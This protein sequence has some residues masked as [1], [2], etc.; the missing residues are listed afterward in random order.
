MELERRDGT[1][2]PAEISHTRLISFAAAFAAVYGT[3]RLFPILVL[4]GG[5]G[6]VFSTTE[7][8][9]PLLG[10]VLGPYAGPV[11]AVVGTFLGI[12][13]TGRTNFFGLDFLAP[14]MNALVLGLLMRR[15]W[16]LSVLIYSALLAL[17]FVH[18][19]TL[20][21]VSVPFLN[22]TTEFPFIWLHIVVWVL[23]VSPLGRR[24]VEWI[25]GATRWKAIVSACLLAL[26]GTM[27]Q[28]LTGTLIFASMAVPLMGL[29]PQSLAKAWL[30]IFYV[31]PI[32]RLVVVLPAATLVTFAVVKALKATGLLHQPSGMK[33]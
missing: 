24:P 30:A 1:M 33:S 17:F 6:R 23:L 32:E 25:S 9:A 11:A 29:T 13:I 14:M 15:K 4:I 20:H 31:Y 26:I 28:H 7:F 18:P 16:L 5:S 2:I 22:G 10:V 3:F 12:M 21:F 27:T 19:S 8:I